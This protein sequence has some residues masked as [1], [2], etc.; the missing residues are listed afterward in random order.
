LGK[1]VKRI[2]KNFKKKEKI[3]SNYLQKNSLIF[4]IFLVKKIE[5]CQEKNIDIDI[6]TLLKN[7]KVSFVLSPSLKGQRKL[8]K[9]GVEGTFTN[10]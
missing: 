4:P 9:L 1:T 6:L 5:T 3:Y 7:S 2:D 10:R 8:C